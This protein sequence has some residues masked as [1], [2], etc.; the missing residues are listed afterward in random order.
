MVQAQE[1]GDRR[2][3]VLDLTTELDAALT[4]DLAADQDVDVSEMPRK[5]DALED[6]AKGHTA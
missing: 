5:D 3:A 4:G 6:R 1:R 2:Y